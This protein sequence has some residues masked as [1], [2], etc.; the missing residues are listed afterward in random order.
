LSSRRCAAVSPP[1]P[2]PPSIG[3]REAA[4]EHPALARLARGKPTPPWSGPKPRRKQ[5]IGALRVF[6]HSDRQRRRS[7]NLRRHIPAARPPDAALQPEHAPTWA[8]PRRP[9]LPRVT[10]AS[11]TRAP[12]SPTTPQPQ[13]CQSSTRAPGHQVPD[14]VNAVLRR[15]GCRTVPYDAR[16]PAATTRKGP[17]LGFYVVAGVG[18]E[19][20]YA[21]PTILQTVVAEVH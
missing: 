10:A 19:P 4:A 2:G 18:F 5:A 3:P 9:R 17:D 12:R 14:Q 21:E 13:P 8:I 20:T 11:R 1:G 15:R 6:E 16:R 7:G